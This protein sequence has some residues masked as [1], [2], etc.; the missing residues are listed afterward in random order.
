MKGLRHFII[1]LPKDYN[2]TF[3]TKGG[4]ELYADRKISSSLLS[5]RV[6]KVVSTPL[7]QNSEIQPGYEVMFDD[8][9]TRRQIY[10][11]VEQES[12]FLVDRQKKYYKLESGMIILYREDAESE[13]KA[14]GSN[15]MVEFIEEIQ[16]EVK[17]SLILMPE[18]KNSKHV[19]G[20][21]KVLYPSA[22][23]TDN[24]ITAGD[25]IAIQADAGIPYYVDGK[26]WYHIENRHVLGLIVKEA[27]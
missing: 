9:I 25:E 14:N 7:L 6:A 27:V 19:K 2:E 21:A 18:S 1:E 10:A 16:E 15:V 17:S 3:T 12:I 20:R 26:T 8:T 4:L 13:W 11:G 23:L 5:V 24:G 22:E